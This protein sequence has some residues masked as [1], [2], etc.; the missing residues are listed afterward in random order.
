M[1]DTLLSLSPAERRQRERFA[2]KSTAVAENMLRRVRALSHC[3]D[4]LSP[5]LD[6]LRRVYIDKEDVQ[7]P[8]GV[9]TVGTYCVMVPPELVYAHGAMPVKLCSGSYTAFSIGDDHAPRD[10]CPLVKAVMGAETIDALPVYQNC[11][12][13]AVPVTCDCK[14]K[15]AGWLSQRRPTATLYVPSNRERDESLEQFVRALYGLSD[16]LAAVT[17]VPLRYEG[18]EYGCRVMANAQRELSRFIALRR[19]YPTVLRGSFAMAVMNAMSYTWAPRW[20][21]QLR[22]LNDELEQ[23]AK[24]GERAVRDNTPRILLTG[25]PVAFPNFKLPLLIEEMGGLLAADETCM[26]ERGLYDPPALVDRSVDGILRALANRATRPCTCPS[27][28]D[29][30]RRLYRVRQLIEDY[31]IQGVI[32]HV[33]RGCLVYDYE[34]RRMEEE[35]EKLGI[36][37]IRIETDYNE[38]DVE[39]LRIR[40]EAFLELIKYGGAL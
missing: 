11:S 13:M 7:T 15:L 5:F 23:R 20:T 27:F 22:A 37:V 3:P 32:Y 38:E 40:V 33:L 30:R 39:Q 10:A 6:T 17:G 4:A 34:Y 8:E 9:P 14:K 19:R 25:S 35:L 1:N 18:L 29:N 12:L 36:P 16:Q 24:A 28:T 2:R 26:G 21:R 31:Q